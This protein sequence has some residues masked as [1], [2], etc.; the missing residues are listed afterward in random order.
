MLHARVVDA[1]TFLHHLIRVTMLA[2][3]IRRRVPYSLRQIAASVIYRNRMPTRV[4]RQCSGAN[5]LSPS[6]SIAAWRIYS[7]SPDPE[8]Q[9]SLPMLVADAEVFVPSFRTPFRVFFFTF[10]TIPYIDKE[11]SIAEVV[12]GAKYV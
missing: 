6:P 1:R 10:K 5:M 11:F 2:P 7:T 8:P 12:D 4:A 3:V 9:V